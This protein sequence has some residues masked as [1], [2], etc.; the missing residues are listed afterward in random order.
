MLERNVINALTVISVLSM[1]VFLVTAPNGPPSAGRMK[2]SQT[3]QQKCVNA[4]PNIL[5]TLVR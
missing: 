3:A 1:V 2:T 4:H 5:V